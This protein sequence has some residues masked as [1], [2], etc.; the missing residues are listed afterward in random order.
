MP[1]VAANASA[2]APSWLWSTPAGGVLVSWNAPMYTEP[3]KAGKPL[4]SPYSEVIV[5]QLS[6]VCTPSPAKKLSM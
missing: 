1:L 5:D 6:F 2:S 3:L 4:P